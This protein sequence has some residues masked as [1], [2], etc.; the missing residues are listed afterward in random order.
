MPYPA[1]CGL[2]SSSDN[3]KSEEKQKVG[4]I[5]ATPSPNSGPKIIMYVFKT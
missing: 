3:G 4:A 2:Y 5:G 1:F